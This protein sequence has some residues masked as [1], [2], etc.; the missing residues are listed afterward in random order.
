M[1]VMDTKYSLSRFNNYTPD[2]VVGTSFYKRNH[3][4]LIKQLGLDTK[5]FNR[6]PIVVELVP[7]PDN[8]HSPSRQAISVRWN[9]KVLGHIKESEV[10]NYQQIKRLTASGLTP[11]CDATYIAYESQNWEDFDP[12]RQRG[13]ESVLV[14]KIDLNIDDFNYLVPLNDP[15]EEGWT[16]LPVGSTIQVTKENE[17]HDHLLEFVPESGEGLLLASLHIVEA[18]VRT[19]FE[20]VEVR[21]EGTTIGVLTKGSSLRYVDAI[22]H[23]DALGLTTVVYAKIKG[24]SLAAEVTI[25]A[26]KSNEL[27]NDDL[28]PVISP[29]KRLVPFQVNPA[30]YD[31]PDAWPGEFIVMGHAANWANSVKASAESWKKHVNEQRPP[32]ISEANEIGREKLAKY[33]KPVLQG[34]GCLLGASVF[35]LVSIIL[36]SIILVAT[37]AK[38]SN[39]LVGLSLVAMIAGGYLGARWFGKFSKK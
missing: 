30:D 26:L 13:P 36:L 20:Q 38:E 31:V 28:D 27:S 12:D 39:G 15:P 11:V 8:P 16:L 23:F 33:P 4:A 22:K 18:G 29:M 35:L 1:K 3:L 32:T 2:L 14:T 5:E 7:E 19:K 34:L 6:V 21:L 37:G 9:D 24:S 17:H 25:H 10:A